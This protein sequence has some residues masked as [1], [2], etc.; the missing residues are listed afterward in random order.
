MGV[1]AGVI[2]AGLAAVE[3]TADTGPLQAALNRASAMMRGYAGSVA[4]AGVS[5]GIAGGFL[6][7]PIVDL[8]RRA[9]GDAAS[10][11]SLGLQLGLTAEKAS[12]LAYA[13][14]TI[15]VDQEELVRFA[16]HMSSKFV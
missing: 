9:V 15:G 4:K 8:F 3:L 5:L 1:G 11:A 7:G 2:R 16:G 10:M 13:M 6:A 12:A 14:G